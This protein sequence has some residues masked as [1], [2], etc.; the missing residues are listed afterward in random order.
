MMEAHQNGDGGPDG[1]D[2]QEFGHTDVVAR[3]PEMA[4]VVA[5]LGSTWNA[6]ATPF[7]NTLFEVS[8]LDPQTRAL[9]LTALQAIN[10]WEAGVRYNAS[11]AIDAGLTPDQVRGAIVCTYPIGGIGALAQGLTWVDRYLSD[12]GKASDLRAEPPAGG[13]VEST[14]RYRRATF[15]EQNPDVAA[16]LESIGP[17]WDIAG[18]PFLE[19]LFAASGM[20][21]KTRELILVAGSAVKGWEA[22]VRFHARIAVDDGGATDNDVRGA[23]LCTLPV[24]GLG[25]AARALQCLAQTPGT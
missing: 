3:N 22:G 13:T 7:L 17:M 4:A 20:P 6:R 10:G 19:A 16:L 23:V 2:V 18:A 5:F 12:A 24:A 25:T 8:G 1:G 9:I 11:R 14:S 15:A 21:V